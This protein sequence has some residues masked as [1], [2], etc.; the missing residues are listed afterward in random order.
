MT[1]EHSENGDRRRKDPWDNVKSIAVLVSLFV[2]FAGII[3]SYTSIANA[4]GGQGKA[5]ESI[6][7]EIKDMKAGMA[8]QQVPSA[9]VTLRVDYIEARINELRAIG[10]DNSRR[11]T[12]L[13]TKIL[14]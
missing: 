5:I 12:Q 3:A 9:T 11:L 4:V 14:R 8:Q 6:L 1:T 7:V 2:V 13:E 10:N